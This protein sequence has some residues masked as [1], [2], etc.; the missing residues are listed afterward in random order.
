MTTHPLHGRR[1]HDSV[2]A[3]I[4]DFVHDELISHE[5]REKQFTETQVEAAR[6]VIF[7]AFPN[8]EEGL[9]AHREHHAALMAS[10]KA[11]REYWE[12]AKAELLKH[13]IGAVLTV[14]KGLLLLAAAGALF[15]LGL[16]E[17]A[18][19]VLGK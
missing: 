3:E 7:R 14:I 4:Q 17:Q 13:G 2:A 9:E 12:M 5:E 8:G 19:K 10:A 18:V 6:A 11:E 15:K 16:G 1:K